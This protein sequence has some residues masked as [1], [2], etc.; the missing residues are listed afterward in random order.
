MLTNCGE[1]KWRAER[2]GGTSVCARRVQ[3][4]G[5][6]ERWR[7]LRWPKLELQMSAS[8]HVRHQCAVAN[9]APLG[10]MGAGSAMASVAVA[11]VNV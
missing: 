5:R 6:K 2:G 9:P 1:H 7:A 11:K 4:T 10:A 3:Q 8:A